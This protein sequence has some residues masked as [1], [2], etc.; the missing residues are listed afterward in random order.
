MEANG[1]IVLLVEDDPGQARLAQRRLG[2]EGYRVEWAETAARSRELLERLSPDVVLLDRGLPDGDGLELLREF[3]ERRPECSIVMLTGADD[4]TLAVAAMRAGA[5]D[6]VL[7]RPDLSHLDD[8]PLV[9][10]RNLQHLELLREREALDAAVRASEARYRTL[11]ENASD[12][13]LVCDA[14][15]TIVEANRAFESLAGISEGEAAGVSLASFFAESSPLD[16]ERLLDRARDGGAT[17]EVHLRSRGGRVAIVEFCLGAVSSED[18]AF[19]G[20]QAIGRDMTEKRRIEE[21]KND[22]LA[23]VTHDMKNPVSVI[24]GYT[25][26]LLNDVCPQ[27]PCREMLVGIDSCARGLLH[28]I[29]NFLDLSRIEAGGIPLR[30]ERV[31]LNDILE[32]V[33]RYESPLAKAK[34]I[35]LETKLAVLPLVEADRVQL[36]RVFTNLVGNAIKFTPAGG[37]VVVESAAK[38][39]SVVIRV[40][41]TGPGIPADELPHLFSKYGRLPSSAHVQGTG[42]GLFIAKSLV[43]AHR[44]RIWAESE[45][46]R[47]ATFLVELP[48]A[49]PR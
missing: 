6:Y 48:V 35:A 37:R 22:F 4:V 25:D 23:M 47:G 21:M 27:A 18:G 5:W 40:R 14:R 41:D 16:L 13:V 11:F 36:D 10:R 38:D 44:G 42:L 49:T 19:A 45:P 12:I 34:G 2:R 3:R 39:S 43:E 26:I 30:L 1:P 31:D 33:V 17:A 7:K 46:G 20:F 24:V 8:L 9:V 32:G 28:L 15:G 29:L